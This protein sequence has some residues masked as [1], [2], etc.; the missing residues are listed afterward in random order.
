MRSVTISRELSQTRK[1]E[2]GR[3]LENLR[4]SGDLGMHTCA[5]ISSSSILG[6]SG[7]YIYKERSSNT[8]NY[9]VQT[10]RIDAMGVSA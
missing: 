10:S 4:A 7:A 5:V 2:C 3:T 1:S 8:K 6:A 9:R